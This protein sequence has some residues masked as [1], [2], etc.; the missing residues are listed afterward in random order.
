M[1]FLREPLNI[2][3]NTPDSP[4]MSV[5]KPDF[6]SFIESYVFNTMNT[7]VDGE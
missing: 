4:E 5:I 1:A 6:V 7:I 3:N 2:L